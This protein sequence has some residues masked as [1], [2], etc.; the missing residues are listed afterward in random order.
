MSV[1][2]DPEHDALARPGVHVIGE[3]ASEVEVTLSNA[4][5]LV[6]DA[7]DSV[8]DQQWALADGRR[9]A[10]LHGR[11]RQGSNVVGHRLRE[12]HRVE[13]HR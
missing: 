9:G 3:L 10:G 4:E 13:H 8:P 1:A 5:A 7:H 2:D 6:V 12:G 11:H